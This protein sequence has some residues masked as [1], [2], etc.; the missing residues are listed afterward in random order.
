MF[1][2]IDPGLTG[3][4]AA[5]GRDGGLLWVIDMP[6]RAKG[7]RIRSEVCPLQLTELLTQHIAPGVSQGVH[8]VVEKISARETDRGKI[9][10]IAS[11]IHSAAIAEG[12]LAGLGCQVLSVEPLTWKRAMGLIKAGKAGALSQARRLFPSAPLDLGKHHNRAEALLLA[13]FCWLQHVDP[14]TGQLRGSVERI[15][16]DSSA[17]DCSVMGEPRVKAENP[18]TERVEAFG[19]VSAPRREAVKR[20][21]QKKGQKRKVEEEDL[22]VLVL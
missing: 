12:V 10:S 6:T 15:T 9:L 7:G 21:Q 13:R 2:G 3:A 4:A 19:G 11:L 18:A 17:S 16:G 20:S 22:G 5:V 1:V 8:G 14:K